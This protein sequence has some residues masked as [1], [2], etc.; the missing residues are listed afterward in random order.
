[1]QPKTKA[2]AQRRI[3]D[4]EEQHA[5]AATGAHNLRGLRR[6]GDRVARKDYEQSAAQCRAEANR[7]RAL[8]PTLPE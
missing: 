1:M 3:D 5:R 6:E 8:L 7:L 2:E 4:L